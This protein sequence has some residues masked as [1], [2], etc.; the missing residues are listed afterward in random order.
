MKIK[1]LVP[2]NNGKFEFTKEELEALLK[3]AYDEG[4]SD[5]YYPISTTSIQWPNA[6]YCNN[7][8]ADT[9]GVCSTL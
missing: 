5:H 6:I 4:Y 3:E 7:Q 9:G 1:V 2:N 8:Q